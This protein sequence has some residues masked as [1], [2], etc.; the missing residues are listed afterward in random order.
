MKKAAKSWKTTAAGIAGGIG[1]LATQIQAVL[2]ND[3]T[4]V[5]SWEMC[6][7]ALGALGIG[8]FSR[9]NDKT[10]KDVGNE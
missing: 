5:F 7:L 2:D 10:S 1:L 4:T 8:W 3:P 9:D 6:M